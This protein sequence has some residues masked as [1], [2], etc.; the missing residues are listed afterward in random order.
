MNVQA[1]QAAFRLATTLPV[2]TVT[3]RPAPAPMPKEQRRLI[4]RDA[5]IRRLYAQG[6]TMER[7]GNAVGLTKSSVWKRLKGKK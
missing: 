3:A 1:Q 7:V 5:K 6:W 2:R 4:E